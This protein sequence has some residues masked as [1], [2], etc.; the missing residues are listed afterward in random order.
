MSVSFNI[1][2]ECKTPSALG[3]T[4]Y[5]FFYGSIDGIELGAPCDSHEE[6]IKEME[7]VL[8]RTKPYSIEEYLTESIDNYQRNIPQAKPDVAEKLLALMNRHQVL[9]KKLVAFKRCSEK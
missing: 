9:L 7:E 3:M 2:T 6:A 5:I 8:T 4:G 1:T